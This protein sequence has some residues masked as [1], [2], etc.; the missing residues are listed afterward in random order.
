VSDTFTR[1]R[2]KLTLVCIES[3][4]CVCEKSHSACGH[5]TLRVET[6]LVRVEITLM[7]VKITLC[8][9]KLHSACINHTRECHIYTHMRQTY[10]RVCRNHTLC[11]KSHSA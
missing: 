8:V 4:L 5:L 2:V 11:V 1:I 9:Q 3:T 10:S 7:R 6:N